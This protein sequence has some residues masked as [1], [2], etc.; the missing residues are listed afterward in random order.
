M[1]KHMR[2][3]TKQRKGSRPVKNPRVSSHHGPAMAGPGVR[4]ACGTD[5]MNDHPPSSLV[6][7]CWADRIRLIAIETMKGAF[8]NE[9]ALHF[10]GTRMT[11]IRYVRE[12]IDARWHA[13]FSRPEDLKRQKAEQ[14]IFCAAV[15]ELFRP[16]HMVW[17]RVFYAEWEARHVR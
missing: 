9:C 5:E 6:A 17:C 3:K 11:Q 12:H 15:A 8:G 2:C 14:Q 7:K 1:K 16:A 13:S 10:C 4:P